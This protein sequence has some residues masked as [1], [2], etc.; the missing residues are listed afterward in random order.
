MP[1]IWLVSLFISLIIPNMFKPSPTIIFTLMYIL[2]TFVLSKTIS[3]IKSSGG[4]IWCFAQG[5]LPIIL[6]SNYMLGK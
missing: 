3:P 1:I 2:V 6:L 4:S 5:A